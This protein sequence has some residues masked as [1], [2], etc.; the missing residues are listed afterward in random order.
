MTEKT[1][2]ELEHYE[3]IPVVKLSGLVTA[4][5]MSP[6]VALFALVG[7]LVTL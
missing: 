7:W 2:P 1:H 4:L 3:P 6:V 5:A